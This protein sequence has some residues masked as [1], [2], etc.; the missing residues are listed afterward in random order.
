MNPIR[1]KL[2]WQILLTLALAALFGAFILPNTGE[3]FSYG[4]IGFC[5]FTGKLFM[6]A[7]KMVIVPLIV[8][9]II[10]GVMHLGAEKGVGRM[11]FKT[12]LY[13]TFSGAAAVIVGLIMVN[14]IQ[15]G[16]VE[17]ATAA[18]MLGSGA[19]TSIS[20]GLMSKVEGRSSSDLFEIFLRMFPSNI[21]DAATNNGQLLGVITFSILFGAFIGKLKPEQRTT[22]QKFWESAQEVMLK[23]TDFIIR[24]A[25]IGVFG[26]VVPVIFETEI[27]DLFGTLAWFFI[28][29]LLALAL[30]FAINLALVLKFVGKV[31]PLTHY[32]EMAPVLLT[33]FSTASSSA[34]LP[35][36]MEIV[37]E[38]AGVSNKTCSFTLPL[39]ATVNMDGTALYECVVVLFIAQLYASTGQIALGIGDQL[40]VVVL[41]L[42]TS[43]GVAGIPAASLV[44][45]AVILPAVGLPVE[46]IGVVWLTDRILDMCRT[47][48]NVFSDTVGAVVIAATEGELPYGKNSEE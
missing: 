13:Y 6:N 23:L 42:T 7:L 28:T 40:L 44:A 14:L 37:E 11:G 21:V 43:I 26:L 19:E 9:S 39:G 41:A 8:A 31:N 35:L 12:F 38:R 4:F 15:P 46:A 18:G 47:S 5:Q 16:Q 24:F 20:Q 25:P 32:K 45:I 1:W 29:V 10:S 27:A 33:A 22:Q 36:T 3:G 30:H 17:A 2:H 34:T 48:V